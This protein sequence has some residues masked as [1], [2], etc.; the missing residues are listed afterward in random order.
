MAARTRARIPWDSLEQAAAVMRVLAHPHR[1][2]L[3]ELLESD[4]MPVGALADALGLPPNAV[5][6]HL[7]ILRAHGIVDRRRR[8]KSVYYRVV[9]PSASW[10]LS[11][12]RRHSCRTE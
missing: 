7:A 8:G 4:G 1:L 10:M 5:S 2:R 6:Q 3:C 9:H 11:C 12:I